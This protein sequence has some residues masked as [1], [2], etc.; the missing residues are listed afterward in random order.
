MDGFGSGWVF[1]KNLRIFRVRFISDS[2]Q[3][4]Q[5]QNPKISGDLGSG[6]FLTGLDKTL[7]YY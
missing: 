5:F 1:P 6:Q 3:E 7:L 2:S 4:N